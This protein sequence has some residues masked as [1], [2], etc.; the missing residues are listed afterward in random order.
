M[1]IVMVT[2]NDEVVRDG[3]RSYLGTTDRGADEILGKPLE[4]DA[5][6]AALAALA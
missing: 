3:G 1:P 4:P 5:L 6:L 2:G